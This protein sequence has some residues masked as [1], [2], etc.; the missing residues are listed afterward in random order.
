[1]WKGMVSFGLVSIPIHLYSATEGKS[2]SFRQVHVADGGRVQYKRVCTV[3][4]EEVPY[5][6][7]GKGYELPDGQ[8]VVLTDADLAQVPVSTSQEIEV[9]EFLPLEAVDPIWFDRSYY[10]EPQKAAIKPYVLLRDALA[11]SGKVALVKV[12]LRQRESMALLRVRGDVIVM[13]TLLW[14]EEVRSP[15]FGFLHEQ[16]QVRDQELTMAGSLIESM[17]EEVFDPDAHTDSYQEA[18]RELIDAKAEGKDTTLPGEPKD[19]EAEVIDLVSALQ[20]SISAKQPDD[21]AA[22]GA[23]KGTAGKA[24]AAKGSAPDKSAADKA[25]A[26]KASAAKGSGGK[27][28]A[29]K[30]SASKTS[31]SSKATA[32]GKSGTRRDKSA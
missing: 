29:A 16:V 6:D 12:T 20:A 2:L 1:M 23:A 28:S 25:S 13:N 21:G 26:S 9:L 17:S 7:I 18:L 4:G 3:D 27:A 15:D 10:M 22:K 24:S 5:A 8:M 30:T 11:K 31:A 19:R 32:S 14:P